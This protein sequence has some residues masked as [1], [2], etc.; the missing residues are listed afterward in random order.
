MSPPEQNR[1]K[2][3]QGKVTTPSGLEGKREYWLREKWSLQHGTFHVGKREFWL[4]EKW[5]CQC[6]VSS[7]WQPSKDKEL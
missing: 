7:G 6:Q 3:K 5:S 1:E 2:I 4:R